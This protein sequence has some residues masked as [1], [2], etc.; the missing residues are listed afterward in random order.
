M[1]CCLL[2]QDVGSSAEPGRRLSNAEL[3]LRAGLTQLPP[4]SPTGNQLVGKFPGK[5]T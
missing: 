2:Q 4:L 3:G 1:P 5:T